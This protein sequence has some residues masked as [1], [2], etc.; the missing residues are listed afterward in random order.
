MA[1]KLSDVEGLLIKDGFYGRM[2]HSRM[3]TGRFIFLVHIRYRNG[4]QC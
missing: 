4:R 2:D 3:S 1:E